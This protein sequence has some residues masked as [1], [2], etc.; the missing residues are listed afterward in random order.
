MIDMQ[1]IDESSLIHTQSKIFFSF[2]LRNY[3]DLLFDALSN[4]LAAHR[5]NP[6]ITPLKIITTACF[7]PMD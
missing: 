3:N 2:A 1:G 4:R 6:F 5:N 7:M